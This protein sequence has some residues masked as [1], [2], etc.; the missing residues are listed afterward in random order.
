VFRLADQ[1]QH[2]FTALERQV[3]VEHHKIRNHRIRKGTFAAQKTESIAASFDNM[4]I[5]IGAF[6]ADRHAKQIDIRRVI[7][8]YQY[9][10]AWFMQRR[11]SVHERFPAP[12]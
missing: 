8:D 10:Y 11:A 3:Q 12:G 6:L 2:L 1:S 7:F 5:A 4:E 9:L